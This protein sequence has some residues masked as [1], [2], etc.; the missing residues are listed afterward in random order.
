MP[1][2]LS[3]NQLTLVNSLTIGIPSFILAMEP[4]ESLV[5]GR[6]MRNVL[7][8]AL[9]A[10]LT[11]VALIVGV[12][13]FYIAFDLDRSMLSTICTGVMGVVGLMMVHQT[14]KPYNLVRKI[15]MVSLTVAYVVAYLICTHY[16]LDIAQLVRLDLRS[17]M[18]LIV[19]GLLA[20]PIFTVLTQACD[21]MRERWQIYTEVRQ[22]HKKL[23]KEK[24]K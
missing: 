3:P 14:S 23:K 8:R 22:K 21:R 7:L 24:A 6:F 5:K 15:M 11:D 2:P 9:P 13:G 17:I 20:W 16:E 1:Y 18:I 19:L 10:A 4:N 12:L